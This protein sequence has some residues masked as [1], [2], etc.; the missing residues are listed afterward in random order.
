MTSQS[1]LF[2]QDR[3]DLHRA[4]EIF[5]RL[6]LL[7]LLLGSCLLILRPFLPLIAWGIIIAVAGDP[8]HRKLQRMV[9]GRGTLSAVLFTLALLAVLMVPVIFLAGTLVEGGQNLAAYL[10]E[11]RLTLPPPPPRLETWPIIGVPVKNAWSS[12]S[13]NLTEVLQRFT[14]QIKSLVSALLS[15]SAGLGLAVLQFALSILL[16]G[17]LLAN[18]RRAT[19]ITRSLATRLLGPRGQEFEQLV[20]STI[21]NVTTGILGVAL[22]QT[23]F[24]AI[25]FL[26]VGLAGAALWII[27]FFLAAVLQVGVVVLI[28]ALIY[29]LAT[30][31]TTKAA[32]FLVWC[33]IVGLMDNVLKPILLGRGAAVPIAVVFLGA[34]GGFV[35]MG[36]IGLF[37]GAIILSVGYKLFLAWLDD[38]TAP[39]P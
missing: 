20:G 13:T 4:L 9:G 16:A 2:Q 19:E 14:P 31:S 21:R 18:P 28:P 12:L 24:A 34:I 27:A 1:F 10:R 7:A 6:G 15:A 33:V 32:I 30:A 25:G 37:V 36:L 5:I 11:G 39:A 23:V 38:S 22:I 3:V 17:V 8:A 35:A 29:V 26:A